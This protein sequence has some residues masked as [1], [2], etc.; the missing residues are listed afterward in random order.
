MWEVDERGECE[1]GW[2]WT[3]EMSRRSEFNK[4]ES[5][6]EGGGLDYKEGWVEQ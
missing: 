4:S 1:C 3:N 5:S 6:S 2:E